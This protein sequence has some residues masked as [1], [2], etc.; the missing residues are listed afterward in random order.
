[1]AGASARRS[2]MAPAGRPTGACSSSKPDHGQPVFVGQRAE[3]RDCIRMFHISNNIEMMTALSSAARACGEAS[4]D[5][6]AYRA[7]SAKP[8]F[9]SQRIESRRRRRRA[10]LPR[11][12]PHS[13]MPG[14]W[15]GSDPD[16]AEP[17]GNG[18][19][20]TG[21]ICIS[22]GSDGQ[23]RP[24]LP[25]RDDRGVAERAARREL[26]EADERD[27][28]DVLRQASARAGRSPR[29][30][31]HSGAASA[32]AAAPHSSKA[33]AGMRRVWSSIR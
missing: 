31:P 21:M 27:G 22:L 23:P 19:A 26:R 28:V 18:R 14:A 7:M 9:P 15:P 30:R 17:S 24:E 25:R 8:L 11:S 33:A 29:R 5:R 32:S 13:R 12:P 4:S 1:M 16:R 3:S 10:G 6:R 2:P 20:G